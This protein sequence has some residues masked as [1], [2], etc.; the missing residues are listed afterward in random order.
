MKT[1]KMTADFDFHVSPQQSV[2]YE[3]GVTYP[4]RPE[5]QVDAIVKAGAGTVVK[6][7]PAKETAAGRK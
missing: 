4:N 2:H 7:E 3:A 6:D 5:A 1:V